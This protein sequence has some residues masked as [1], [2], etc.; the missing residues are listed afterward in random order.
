MDVLRSFLTG[1]VVV[2]VGEIVPLRQLAQAPEGHLVETNTHNV[3][4]SF[5][6]LR[7]A[8]I[9]RPASSMMREL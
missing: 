4:H 7:A 8:Y 2:K 3:F 6:S 5:S 1:T 9:L